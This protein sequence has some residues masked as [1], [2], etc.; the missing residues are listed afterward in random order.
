MISKWTGKQGILW[1]AVPAGR[2]TLTLYIAYNF[3]G[4][5]ILETLVMRGGQS[6]TVAVVAAVLFCAVATIYAL[7]WRRW[8]RR[9]P[10]E[11]LMRT[12]TG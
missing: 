4:M 7:L 9:G 5:G 8:F 1:V 3:V 2:Q 11:V 12:L 10:I 6:I